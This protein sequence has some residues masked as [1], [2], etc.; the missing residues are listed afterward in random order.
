MH[1]ALDG[2]SLG[3]W[4]VWRPEVPLRSGSVQTLAGAWERP[5]VSHPTRRN[6]AGVCAMTL[7][8]GTPG[9][10]QCL[11]VQTGMIRRLANTFS[12][13]LALTVA[14]MVDVTPVNHRHGS[15]WFA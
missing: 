10:R 15:I 13:E 12:G 8:A 4:C 3:V 14:D 2:A 7:P 5:T 1:K 9:A 6:P 11:R